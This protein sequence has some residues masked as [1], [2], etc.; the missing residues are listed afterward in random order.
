MKAISVQK[1]FLAQLE[2][3]HYLGLFLLRLFLGLRLLYGVLDN[4]LHWER[5]LEF[6]VFLENNDF[7]L[8]L[9]SAVVSVYIQLFG[10]I[11]LLVGYKLRFF[12]ILLILNFIV[13]LVF[14]HLAN[15]DTIEGMTPALAI[16][17]GCLALF[18]TQSR[19]NFN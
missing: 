19:E 18:F 13:A 9:I 6:A 5:M 15:N 7:P 3:R 16:L 12:S 8:P 10:A 2:S 11:S 14:V 4:V 1:T 17:F